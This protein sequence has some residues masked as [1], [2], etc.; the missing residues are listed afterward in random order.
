MSSDSYLRLDGENV[1]VTRSDNNVPVRIPLHNL[2]GIVCFNYQGISPAL[3]GK[4]VDLGIDVSFLT[5]E[6][7]FLARVNGIPNGNV[8][9][10]RQQ[11]KI[12]E[13]SDK[14]V[15]RTHSE[16]VKAFKDIFSNYRLK[17]LILISIFS[18]AFIYLI[19]SGISLSC[20]Q[21]P[22][23]ITFPA[24]AVAINIELFSC[25]NERLK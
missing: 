15:E 1:V 25:K 16:F 23:P 20:A 22:P 11:Y 18:P 17:L 3:M 19:Q 5:P 24:R 13:V 7:R 12:A 4:C 21:S 6:G 2:E 14:K 8:L 10:R 9:L